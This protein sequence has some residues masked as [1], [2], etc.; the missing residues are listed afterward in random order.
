MTGAG[1]GIG[2]ATAAALAEPGGV[3][4]V[5]YRSNDGAAAAACSRVVRAGARAVRVKADVTDPAQVDALF[6]EISK[7]AGGLDVLVLNAGLPARYERLGQM[8]PETFEAQWRSQ[9]FSAFLCLRRALPLLSKAGG[10]VVF[11]LS[12][13]TAGDPPGYM[14]GYV[15]AKYALLGLAR[16]LA[17]EAGAKGPRVHCVSPGMT[18][19]DFIK[20]FPR[21]VVEAASE[22]QG[23]LRSPDSVAAEVLGLLG[24]G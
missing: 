5:N 9:A 17:A 2:A 8:S 7:E 13:V 11:I 24:R 14:A 12:S 19:T 15:A 4:V 18:E 20:D 3:V 23:G 22:A 21:P 16:A 6:A 1:R 10:D